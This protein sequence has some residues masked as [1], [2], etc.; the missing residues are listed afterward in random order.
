MY[1]NIETINYLTSQDGIV[2][3][4]YTTSQTRRSRKS[5]THAQR[6]SFPPLSLNEKGEGCN[7]FIYS[8][9][10]EQSVTFVLFGSQVF[11]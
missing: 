10:I 9:Y 11:S 6:L 1:A 8:T 7:P 5:I 4:G 3:K 2:L